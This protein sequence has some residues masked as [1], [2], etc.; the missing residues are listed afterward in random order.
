MSER[1][2]KVFGPLLKEIRTQKRIT[3]REFCKRANA[4]PGNVSR[5][6][7]GVWP[8]P[9]DADILERYAHALG[10]K[11]GTDDWYRFFDS[12]ATDRGIVP[13]D[14]MDDEEVVKMLPVFFRT[15]RGTKPTEEEMKALVEKI[16]KS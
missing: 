13:R 7:R 3:L 12:A 4:D 6:E 10:L 5:I 16:R 14:I 2:D 1:E 15:L 8:P 11:E 9:Q